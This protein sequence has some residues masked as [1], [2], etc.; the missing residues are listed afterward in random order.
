MVRRRTLEVVER[1]TLPAHE[2]GEAASRV[3]S[4]RLALEQFF[5]LHEQRTR[6]NSRRS[7][8]LIRTARPKAPAFQK[9]E[10][11]APK[12]QK[13]PDKPGQPVQGSNFYEALVQIPVA[14]NPIGEPTFISTKTAEMTTIV[15][16]VISRIEIEISRFSLLF[17]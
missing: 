13:R 7:P 4:Q 10:D 11:R 8:A 16:P 5:V 1:G 17:E 6:S 15:N 14:L 3:A 12:L 9:A 2:S